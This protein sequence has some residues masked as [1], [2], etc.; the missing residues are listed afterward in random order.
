MKC[1]DEQAASTNIR[2]I[3]KDGVFDYA[4]AVLND[5]LILLGPRGA[6]H[7]GDGPRIIHCWKFMILYWWHVGHT[8]YFNEAVQLISAIEALASQIIAHELIWCRTV[9]SRGG[10]G[11]NIPADLFL[12][13]LNRT[14]KEY[15]NGIGP[16]VS[17]NTIV[18]A[19][20]SLKCLLQI[21]NHFDQVCNVRSV[22][23]DH[24]KSSSQQ[25]RD[26]IIHE[27]AIESKVFNYIPGQ[28]H[29]T[30]KSI[31]PHI[32]SHFDV[33]KLTKKIEHTKET[34]SK[35]HELKKIFTKA[36]QT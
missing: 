21:S 3:S 27:L 18:Q 24:T 28:Y 12:E 17:K 2:Q 7:E 10:A 9:N 35:S 14:L 4:S 26:K 33:Y 25:D 5:G 6:I 34:I 8:K 13:H 15:L 22:S 20:K 16:N 36:Y 32:S 29:S 19:S 1:A 31:C 11:N 30:F 23:M